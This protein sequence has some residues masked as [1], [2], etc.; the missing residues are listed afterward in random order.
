MRDVVGRAS[1][2]RAAPTTTT[3]S[4]S[5]RR[6]ARAPVSTVSRMQFI[7]VTAGPLERAFSLATVRLHTAAATDARPAPGRETDLWPASRR[8]ARRRQRALSASARPELAPP[9]SASPRWYAAAAQRSPSPFLLLPTAFGLDS[10]TNT[11]P[12]L[13]VISAVLVLGGSSPGSLRARHRENRHRS[14]SRAAAAP[15]TTVPLAQ[16][17]RSNS[18]TTRARQLFRVAED[19]DCERRRAG[20]RQRLRRGARG[21][22]SFA[23]S[24][25]PLAQRRRTIAAD[26]SATAEEDA[27]WQRCNGAADRRDGAGDG[28]LIAILAGLQHRLLH[29]SGRGHE[30]LGGGGFVWAF[31]MGSV[32]LAPLSTGIAD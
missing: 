2:R 13:I 21:R 26:A 1:A 14:R 16:V 23:T 7:N 15:V 5:A 4:R 30:A 18:R 19:C 22:T 32:P 3:C 17:Q 9:A 29:R 12:Q 31:S 11:T 28:W 20:P 27:S 6:D 8:M 25:S 10:L 24:C